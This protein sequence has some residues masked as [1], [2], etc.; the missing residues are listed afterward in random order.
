MGRAR[1]ESLFG[2][3]SVADRPRLEVWQGHLSRDVARAVAYRHAAACQGLVAEQAIIVRVPKLI[4][5]AAPE[6][7]LVPE[8]VTISDF[9]AALTLWRWQRAM[10]GKPV[11]TR[12][13]RPC[14][15][16]SA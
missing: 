9:L 5:D 1:G 10:E 12:G 13:T 7:M 11:G 2:S 15:G 14:A 6:T 8:S 3:G 16:A 4:G